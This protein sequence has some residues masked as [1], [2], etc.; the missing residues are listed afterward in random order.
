MDRLRS[1]HE[2]ARGKHP[3]QKYLREDN[4]KAISEILGEYPHLD[5]E[6]NN[7]I[8]DGLDVPTIQKY[9]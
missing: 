1:F 3:N 6:V 9:V 5:D 8:D 7:A 2:E 4:H